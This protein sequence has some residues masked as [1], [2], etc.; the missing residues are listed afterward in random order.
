MEDSGGS[1]RHHIDVPAAHPLAHVREATIDYDTGLARIVLNDGHVVSDHVS[2]PVDLGLVSRST[3]I[4]A[5]SRMEILANGVTLSMTLGT[6]DERL[7]VPVV[8]LD[9]KD[10]IDFAR[11]RNDPD[12][13]EPATREFYALLADA[14]QQ[15]RVVVPISSAHLTETSK[16]AGRSR[17]DLA[18]TMLQY[19]RGWQLR[20]VLGL[21]R[22]ELRALFGAAGH[23]TRHDAVTLL[24]EVILDMPAAG[25]D[26]WRPESDLDAEL[27]GLIRRQ[28]WASVLVSLLLDERAEP[29]AGAEAKARWAASFTGPAVAARDNPKA[30]ARMRDLTRFRFISDL[31]TDLPAAAKEAGL[32]EQDFAHWL[33]HKAET[34]ISA[35]PGLGRLREIL[36]LRI[37]NS[38][39]TWEPNDLNDWLHLSY[40]AAYCDLVV[41][42]KKF[43]NYLRRTQDRT[44]PGASVH[45]RAADALPDLRTLLDGT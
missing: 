27:A 31:G 20:S 6:V 42:E 39:E 8:Y 3:F 19:S 43:T 37:A 18:A 38:Q 14:A 30:K 32:D 11:W 44:T 24:P 16:R 26:T 23:P 12:Q 45:R 33:Q 35:L 40:A 41:G 17:L 7:E 10:W 4:P 15:E 5:Q 34:S 36:H 28:T 1:G 22:A 25:P 9:Q 21:R 13:V 2:I 29:D